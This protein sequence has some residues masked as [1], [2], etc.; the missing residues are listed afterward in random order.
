M[1]CAVTTR[2]MKYNIQHAPKKFP[3]FQVLKLSYFFSKNE[4]KIAQESTFTLQS[5]LVT[6]FTAVKY[7]IKFYI[8]QWHHFSDVTNCVT[9]YEHG[10]V[11]AVNCRRPVFAKMFE[12]G[13]KLECFPNDA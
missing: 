2:L 9:F 7:Y 11:G 6:F 10:A 3:N 4:I 12:S 13:R 1:A 8:F 5:R